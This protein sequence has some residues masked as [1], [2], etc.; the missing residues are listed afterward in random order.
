MRKVIKDTAIVN[1]EDPYWDDGFY[2]QY[3]PHQ[4]QGKCSTGDALKGLQTLFFNIN[5]AYSQHKEESY[6]GKDF[7]NG[8]WKRL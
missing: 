3:I 8:V 4:I 5:E 1:A 7:A 2:N 6:T